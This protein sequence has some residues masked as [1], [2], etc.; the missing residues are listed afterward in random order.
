MR[1]LTSS[2]AATLIA[3]LSC[4]MFARLSHFFRPSTTNLAA[5][6]SLLGTAAVQPTTATAFAASD[7]LRHSSTMSNGEAQYFTGANGC[8][9]GPQ[10]MYTK[11]FKGKGLLDSKVGYIGG[12]TSKPTYEAV[13]SGKTGHAEAIQVKFDPA[14]VSYAELVEFLLRTHDPTQKDRQGADVG[15]QYRSAIFPHN[16][17]QAEI[18]KKVVAEAQEKVRFHSLMGRRADVAVQLT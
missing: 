16:A 8:F 6:S 18:A 7:S 1:S 11:H 4:F 2:V 12:T 14:Q 9:W 17:E 13:C 10:Q 5:S 3:I 15:T